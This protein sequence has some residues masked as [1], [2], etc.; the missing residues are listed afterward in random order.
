M[1]NV[2]EPVVTKLV[3]PV[4]VQR[5]KALLA[6]AALVPKTAVDEDREAPT[7]ECEI[8]SSRNANV[9]NLPPSD[10]GSDQRAAKPG[11]GG[12]VAP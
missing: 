3:R 5:E 9:A 4:R 10:P 12:L 6:T 7:R 2:S 11:F 1:A 8:W